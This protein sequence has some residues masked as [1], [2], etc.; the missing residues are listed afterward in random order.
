MQNADQP[1]SFLT[2]T[3]YFF[4][5]ICVLRFQLDIYITTCSDHDWL[6]NGVYYFQP[7]RKSNNPN[8]GLPTLRA[9]RVFS[10]R[11]LVVFKC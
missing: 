1:V 8:R 11:Y 9:G 2:V 3:K 5:N 4:C 10:L 6:R 7:I